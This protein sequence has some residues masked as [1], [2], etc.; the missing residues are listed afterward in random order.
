MFV[1]QYLI[2]KDL[3]RGAH[4]TVKLV[5]DTEEQ[6][7]YAMKVRSA[8]SE[9]EFATGPG[10]ECCAS[11]YLS[12]CNSFVMAGSVRIRLRSAECSAL[13]AAWHSCCPATNVLLP[14][15]L[16]TRRMHVTS[17]VTATV[18]DPPAPTALHTVAVPI[19][20]QVWPV[21]AA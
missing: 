13:S 5:F 18:Q 8:E 19:W 12:R 1:N 7:V 21:A 17:G 16:Y 11:I 9:V 2:I 15:R 20:E 3:G 6:I 14:C 10:P 4:G